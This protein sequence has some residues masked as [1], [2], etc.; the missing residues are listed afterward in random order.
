VNDLD[1]LQ[2]IWEQITFEVDGERLVYDAP[3]VLTSFTGTRF[4]VHSAE[5]ALLLSGD[6]RLNPL[7]D[8]KSIDWIDDMGPDAGKVLPAIYKLEDDRF[9]FVAADEGQQRPGTILPGPGLSLRCFV[10][11]PDIS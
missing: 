9:I 1:A 11:R 8:P 6:F 4:A 3:G 7:T 2:G 10:R 5:G